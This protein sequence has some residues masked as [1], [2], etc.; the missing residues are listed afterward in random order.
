[1]ARKGLAGIA[2]ASIGSSL[3]LIGCDS[4]DACSEDVV[5]TLIADD[6]DF[7]SYETFAIFDPGDSPGSGGAG[8]AGG[9]EV[10]E[11]VQLNLD[12]ANDAIVDQLNALGLTEV[13]PSE[14]EPDVWVFSAAATTDMVAIQWAC[15]EGWYWWGWYY[16]W[17]PCSWLVPVTYEYTL[18]TLV[19]G[20]A[21]AQTERPVFGGMAQGILECGDV[22]GRV[23]RAVAEVFESY[24]S[25]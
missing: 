22:R 18:G 19:F 20:I 23:E 2:V 5:Q 24:P 7:E 6:A 13:D 17:D 14:T 3:A 15:A 10:P 4:D 9:T 16:Y 1:M 21:D 8:G 25:D 11:N 12:Y